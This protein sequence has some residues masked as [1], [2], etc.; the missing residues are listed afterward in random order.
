[1]RLY[2][3]IFMP[4]LYAHIFAWLCLYGAGTRAE[5]LAAYAVI[6]GQDHLGWTIP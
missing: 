2:A 1:M 3:H 4:C 6:Q 5:L